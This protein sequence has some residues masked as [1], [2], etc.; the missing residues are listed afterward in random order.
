MSAGKGMGGPLVV[1]G[2][3]NADIVLPI[4]RI[5][6]P[7]ETLNASDLRLVPGGKG[8]NQAAAAA[9]LQYATY[10]LGQVGAQCYAEHEKKTFYLQAYVASIY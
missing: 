6:L 3:A 7:G 2:S 10:F 8:A 4:E 9:R 1:V 5:P